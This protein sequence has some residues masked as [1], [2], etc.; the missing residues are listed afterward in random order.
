M[1]SRCIAIGS[2]SSATY[3]SANDDYSLSDDSSDVA[4]RCSLN[5]NSIPK[6]LEQFAVSSAHS[7]RFVRCC[8][9]YTH[10]GVTWRVEYPVKS[11]KCL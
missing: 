5:S 2:G 8:R 4:I 10:V 3:V 9:S 6:K 7:F 11:A 1:T